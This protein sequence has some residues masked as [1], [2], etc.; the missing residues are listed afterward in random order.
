MSAATADWLTKD[1]YAVLGVPPTATDKQITRAYRKLARELHPDTRTGG[2][3]DDRF[4]DVAAAYDVLGDETKRKEYDELRAAA[5]ARSAGRGGRRRAA[6][7][8]G[9]EPDGVRIHV[10]RPGGRPSSG[11]LSDSDA[12][13]EVFDGVS[14]EDLLGG[15]SGFGSPSATSAR[16]S[17]PGRDLRTTVRLSFEQ[18]VRGATVDIPLDGQLPRSVTAR[19]LAGVVDGQTVRLPGRGE[20]GT[21]GGP[22]GDLLVQVAVEPHPLFGRDGRSLTLTV[23]IT[24][25]EAALGADVAVPTLDGP[26]TVRIPPGTA[27]GTTLRVRGRGVPGDSSTPAGDLQVTVQVQVPAHLTPAQRAAVEKLAEATPGSPR[28]HLG[29]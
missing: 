28:D 15:R 16:R 3:S 25:P 1:F 27:S 20:P 14:L 13:Y 29:V 22:P 8:W 11:P 5:A 7:A 24:F 26:V 12:F 10:Q 2:G 23:P 17:R 9:A 21:A 18:A 4:K 6:G 19:I